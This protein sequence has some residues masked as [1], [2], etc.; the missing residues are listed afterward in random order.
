MFKTLSIIA[1]QYV[2]MKISFISQYVI[3]RSLETPITESRERLRDCRH[4]TINKSNN[5][6]KVEALFTLN[7]FMTVA[8]LVVG[9]HE[10][11]SSFFQLSFKS[12]LSAVAC[13]FKRHVCL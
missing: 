9:S 10:E 7:M 12:Q 8:L 1:K 2:Y 11:L 3:T 4:Q 5:G 13:P 6:V